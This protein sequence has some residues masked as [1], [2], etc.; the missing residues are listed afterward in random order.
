[1]PKRRKH[2]SK[3]TGDSFRKHLDAV[4]GV[5][6]NDFKWDHLNLTW[7]K[8]RLPESVVCMVSGVTVA[9][10]SSPKAET[11][12]AASRKVAIT[13]VT[14]TNVFSESVEKVGSP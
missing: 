4:D 10:A 9:K 1:M 13:L 7:P 8:L 6:R 11:T 12:K 5:I 3:Q 14:G 2:S